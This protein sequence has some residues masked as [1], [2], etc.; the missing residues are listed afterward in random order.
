GYYCT[1]FA[2]TNTDLI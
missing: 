1:S 2:G